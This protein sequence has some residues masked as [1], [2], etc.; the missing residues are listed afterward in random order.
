MKIFHF[1]LVFLVFCGCSVNNPDKRDFITIDLIDA[2]KNMETL[3]LSDLVDS[4]EYIRFETSP[5]CSFGLA[6]F[7]VLDRYIIVYEVIN[8]NILLFDRKGKFINKISIKGK[9]PGELNRIRNLIA[10]PGKKILLAHDWSNMKI[11]KFCFDGEFLGEKHFNSKGIN[12]FAEIS[13]IDHEKFAIIYQRPVSETKDF[14]LINICNLDFEV[15][16]Q[17]FPVDT[18]EYVDGYSS[19]RN[20]FY[21]RNSNIDFRE[22]FF[23]TLFVQEKGSFVPRYHFLIKEN[24]AP[25]HVNFR[26]S[27]RDYNELWEQF[28]IGDY[29]VCNMDIPTENEGEF[30]GKWVFYNKR[31]QKILTLPNLPWYFEEDEVEPAIYNDVDGIFHIYMNAYTNRLKTHVSEEVI[32][33]VTDLIDLKQ[34]IE[35]GNQS[36]HT[37]KFPEKQKELIELIRNSS[38]NDNPILQIFY[39]R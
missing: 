12:R 17:I 24:H 36:A 30:I 31:D 15:I 26:G 13:I 29:V 28:E 2:I 16:E 37:V 20:S 33:K 21:I 7:I 19:R 9:G 11:V 39:V 14:H 3:Y 32:Y 8:P 23:D 38:E 22:Y 6:R 4:V 5:E 1:L 10:F 27:S 34:Y 25:S 18:E 35:E